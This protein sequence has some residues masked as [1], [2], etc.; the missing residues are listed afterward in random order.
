MPPDEKETAEGSYVSRVFKESIGSAFTVTPSASFDVFRSV[1]AG[2]MP[3]PSMMIGYAGNFGNSVETITA[4]MAEGAS[5]GKTK[6]D[7]NVYFITSDDVRSRAREWQFKP[8]SVELA[9]LGVRAFI[10]NGMP[11]ADARLMGVMAG[12][13]HPK[14][15]GMGRF[16]PGSIGEHLTS[17]A[18]VFST[19]EQTKLCAWI[20]AGAVASAGTVTEPL[21]NWRKFPSAWL[22]VHYA[23]GCTV[24]ESFY[25]SVRCPLQL[26]IVGDPLAAPWSPRD[27]LT[28]DCPDAVPDRA[29]GV[30]K[31]TASVAVQSD[32]RYTGYTAL[33]DGR[34]LD[35]PIR[36]TGNTCEFDIDP[37]S[38]ATGVHILR[39][40]AYGSGAVRHQSF[41]ERTFIIGKTGKEP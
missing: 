22:F 16:M 12:A 34:T 27:K 13:P 19:V 29:S 14:P 28:L 6:P 40:V 20:E 10:T 30:F 31:A 32:R 35:V 21:S 15:A 1:L 3:L 25:Q 11:P 8:A 24:I 9:D 7:G 39:V 37:S 26:L 36:A 2:R 4:R 17:F 41:A 18:G 33:I 23:R 5:A 38:L